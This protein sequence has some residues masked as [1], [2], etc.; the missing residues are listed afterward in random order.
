MARK[1]IDLT[2]QRFGRLVVLKES[3]KRLSNQVTW[4]CKCECGNTTKVRQYS[5]TTG[6]TKSCGCLKKEYEKVALSNKGPFRQDTLVEG[7]DLRQLY[8]KKQ[9]N[10]TSGVPGVTFRKKEQKWYA[11]IY[12]K[13]KEIRL[14][15]FESKK[16]AIKAR[17]E[18]EKKYFDPILEKY[19][20]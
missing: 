3:K 4:E 6:N 11:R 15:Y 5:L 18:A 9:R 20:K 14:G 2:G 17:K 13:G 1:R 19:D 8:K 12:L 16:D 10:N 7:T